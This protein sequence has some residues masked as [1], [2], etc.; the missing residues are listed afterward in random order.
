MYKERKRDEAKCEDGRK[1]GSE[2]KRT[3]KEEKVEKE[4]KG[5]EKEGE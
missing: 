1:Q 5:E 2:S 4:E 3:R